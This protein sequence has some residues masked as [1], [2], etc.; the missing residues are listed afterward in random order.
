MQN[1]TSKITQAIPLSSEETVSNTD[2]VSQ[3]VIEHCATC[4]VTSFLA[5]HCRADLA[6]LNTADS[7]RRQLIGL[8]ASVRLLYVE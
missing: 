5:H 4:D 1:H 3:K 2:F 8:I 7:R 6:T